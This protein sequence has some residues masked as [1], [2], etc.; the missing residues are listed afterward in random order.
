MPPQRPTAAGVPS[1]EQ[2]WTGS[3]E[4]ISSREGTVISRS[5]SA[6]SKCSYRRWNAAACHE[7]RPS[8][9]S[10]DPH[11]AVCQRTFLLSASED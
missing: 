5:A 4:C 6:R 7:A 3:F 10:I 8:T 11:V 1:V 9:T 2:V